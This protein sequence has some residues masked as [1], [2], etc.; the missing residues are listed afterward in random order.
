MKEAVRFVTVHLLDGKSLVYL[1]FWGWKLSSSIEPNALPLSPLLLHLV[2]ILYDLRKQSSIMVSDLPAQSI[3]RRL[4][5]FHP[6]TF[7]WILT[8]TN[9]LF[10]SKDIEQIKFECMKKAPVRWYEDCSVDI[11]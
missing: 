10:L 5:L 3:N 2:L 6:Y 9:W 11:L 8:E 4:F 1:P 7:L